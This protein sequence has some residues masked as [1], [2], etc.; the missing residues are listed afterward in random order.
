VSE[1]FPRD[2]EEIAASLRERHEQILEVGRRTRLDL[3]E[4]YEQAL[5]ALADSRE[6]LADASEIEWF[7]RMLRAQAGFTREIA[8]A[9]GKF[10]RELLEP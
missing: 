8:E 2:P 10:A 6:Q 9:S 4:S 7:S 3:V 1:W 5:G